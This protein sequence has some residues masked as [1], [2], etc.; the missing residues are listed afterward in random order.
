LFF[1]AVTVSWSI[2]ALAYPKA[3]F[4]PITL[5]VVMLLLHLA[6]TFALL[7][8][9]CRTGV[10]DSRGGL[11]EVLLSTPLG[12]DVF[13]TGRMLKFKRR[14]LGWYIGQILFDAAVVTFAAVA[15]SWTE[16][17][18]LL[19]VA[20]FLVLHLSMDLY[21][22]AWTGFYHG[23]R[24]GGVSAAIR[25]SFVEICLAHVMLVVASLGLLA[26][27][28]TGGLFHDAGLA[29]G[30]LSASYFAFYF[31]TSSHYCGKAMHA[32]RE[33]LPLLALPPGTG[34]PPPDKPPP[35]QKWSLRNFKNRER[36]ASALSI[37]IRTPGHAPRR[38]CLL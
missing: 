29:V 21:A 8:E 12:G 19:A 17:A 25:R 36:P 3:A 18:T 7:L 38:V 33:L 23:L 9:V 35:R 32:L 30:F 22:L 15:L 26:V 1:L 24:L 4:S 16:T 34:E 2:L 28:S 6:L 27:L 13:V 20:L 5:T 14:F 11:L 10:E 31:M 37:P